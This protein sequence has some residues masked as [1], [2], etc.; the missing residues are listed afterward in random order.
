MPFLEKAKEAILSHAVESCIASITVLLAWGVSEIYPWL[1]SSIEAAATKKLLLS[2]LVV[3]VALNFLFL[4]FVWLL[5]KSDTFMLKYGIYWDKHKN[6]HCPSCQKPV[7]TYDD[8][9]HSGKGYYCKP[10]NQV[11]PLA[12][13]AGNNVSPETAVSEL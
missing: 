2:L 8:Y 3:S 1:L 9:G 11:F 12:D 4:A 10:C 6:P 7:A 13:A 5:S